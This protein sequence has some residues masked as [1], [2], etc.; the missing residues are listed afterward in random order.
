MRTVGR[1]L[2]FP[3]MMVTI[4]SLSAYQIPS[5]VMKQ[6]YIALG[7]NVGNRAYYI[8][9]AFQS[10]SDLGT[11]KCSSFLYETPAKYYTDQPN[12]LNAAC[13]IDTALDPIS[14]LKELK[15]IENDIGRKKNFPNG[16]RVIDL[17]L[18][19]Y[20]DDV[21]AFPDLQVPHTR[22]QE[23][24]FVLQPLCDINPNILHPTLKKTMRELFDS[25][26]DELAQ[27]ITRVI[28]LGVSDD[29]CRL[30]DISPEA[31]PLVMGVLN[32]TPDSFSDG[33]K[34]E[35]IE[36][37]IQAVRDMITDG[38]DIIDIGGASS[39][40]GASEV[41][42]E[43]EYRRTVPLIT[44][45]RKSNITAFISIDTN[46]ANIARA[47]VEA[48][49]DII[50]D[51][52]GG[53]HDTDMISTAA[54]LGV[55]LILMHMRGT[56]QNMTS[57]AKY[58]DIIN[59]VASELNEQLSLADPILPRWLQITDPGIGFAKSPAH[60]ITLLNP[61]NLK[62]LRSKLG[63]RTM[64]IGAS[65]KGFLGKLTGVEKASDRD[66]ATA[67]TCCAAITG[68]A[69]IVRVHHVAG[70]RQ[71]CDVMKAIQT[72]KYKFVS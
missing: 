20:N 70:M 38:A 27:E 53:R 22:L 57:K 42:E 49:A 25:L 35:T 58:D 8:Y 51:I 16:P 11:I 71:V 18:L 69:E 19:L 33:G 67:S 66:W 4:R 43:E 26:P 23:R 9:K 1:K 54:Q 21:I 68:G 29:R 40:P 52:S 65:R 59:E 7:S 41:G 34:Y 44:A 3:V 56:S 15:K 45:L 6:A 61:I 14:L 24:A 39:R 37:K 48:G 60:S 50:N 5:Q 31:R 30:V 47:A 10:L 46:R 13:H 63:E 36:E 2:Y 72:N 62:K 32:T 55:P 17:D 64:L 28:P 12:F